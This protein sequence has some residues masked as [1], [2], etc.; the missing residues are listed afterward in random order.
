[1]CSR[2][3]VRVVDFFPPKLEDF[4]ARH[5]VTEFEDLSD[6]DDETESNTSTCA[7]D[8]NSRSGSQDES[9]KSNWEW[10]FCLLLEDASSISKQPH[11]KERMKVFVVGA[12]AEFL[13]KMDAVK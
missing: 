3:T 13:T 7:S 11:E 4:A 5:R 10:R 8:E 12:D 6:N 9:E 2:T 1:M